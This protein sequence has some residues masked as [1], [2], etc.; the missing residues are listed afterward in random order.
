MFYKNLGVKK[1]LKVKYD[2]YRD[3]VLVWVLKRV[4]DQHIA[5]L[6]LWLFLFY[7]YNS[8]KIYTQFCYK[9]SWKFLSLV[10]KGIKI[11]SIVLFLFKLTIIIEF[12]ERIIFQFGKIEKK[13]TYNI[14]IMSLNFC[15]L[16]YHKRYQRIRKLKE[17]DF[18]SKAF[19][20]I[21]F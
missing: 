6:F 4:S 17:I 2:S 12:F 13:P 5:V 8:Y 16:V 20:T 9:E 15:M 10:Q 3:F 7:N 21:R 18:F 14:W 11:K 19:L 1:G